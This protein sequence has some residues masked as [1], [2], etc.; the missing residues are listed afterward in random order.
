MVLQSVVSV[1]RFVSTT[2]YEPND[3]WPLFFCTWVVRDRSSPGTK[4][5]GHGLH[6]L[7]LGLARLDPRSRAVCFLVREPFRLTT[8][9][10]WI[11]VA[12]LI[13]F[14]VRHCIGELLY[15]VGGERV[16]LLAD[17]ESAGQPGLN[18]TPAS[19]ARRRRSLKTQCGRSSWRE[20]PARPLPAGSSIPPPPA[21]LGS[22]HIP[23][24][25]A[26]RCCWSPAS[27]P[28]DTGGRTLASSRTVPRRRRP[29]ARRL[30]AIFVI[31]N[32]EQL[33]R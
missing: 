27:V 24:A 19:A 15:G 18:M 8:Y 32:S 20:A 22:L 10:R 25:A 7:W 13:D 16:S 5:K 14:P 12:Q 6:E 31:V 17:V 30:A 29:P 28:G 3:L 2:A 26:V 1:C 33:G 23:A 21:I 4:I 9:P 11:I